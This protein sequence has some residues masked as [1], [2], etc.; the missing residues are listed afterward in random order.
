MTWPCKSQKHTK[1]KESELVK[2]WNVVWETLGFSDN[3]KIQPGDD[4][5]PT[6]C[7][8]MSSLCRYGLSWNNEQGTCS[9]AKSDKRQPFALSHSDCPNSDEGC[10]C[11]W[12]KHLGPFPHNEPRAPG[13]L[14]VLI[15]HQQTYFSLKCEGHLGES[16]DNGS[17][18]N[19]LRQAGKECAECE[20]GVRK[21]R[22]G[23]LGEGTFKE[24]NMFTKA[25]STKSQPAAA[26][27]ADMGSRSRGCSFLTPFCVENEQISIVN[28]LP[29]MHWWALLIAVTLGWEAW[30]WMDVKR[31]GKTYWTFPV[32]A[33]WNVTLTFSFH[34]PKLIHGP[35]SS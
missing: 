9:R 12:Q 29:W 14:L 27:E 16:R 18:V 3:D 19:A 7:T 28:V 2:I 32:T 30:K 8:T 24:K 15:G 4:E 26:A 1:P 22:G 17:A 11:V 13:W 23:L 31:C 20:W 35:K 21:G 33:C 25:S 6:C 5:T 34:W 10:V